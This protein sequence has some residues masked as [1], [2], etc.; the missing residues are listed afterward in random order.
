MQKRHRTH[1]HYALAITAIVVGGLGAY[2]AFL[3]PSRPADNVPGAFPDYGEAF[4]ELFTRALGL[5]CVFVSLVL[6]AF[7]LGSFWSRREKDSGQTGAQGSPKAAA[8]V[9]P[10]DRPVEKH[11]RS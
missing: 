3:L 9:L 8:P 10:V 5:V 7:A 6:W 2:L 4:S 11:D 1:L